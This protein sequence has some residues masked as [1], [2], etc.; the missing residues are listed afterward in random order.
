MSEP[1]TAVAG[2]APHSREG[3]GRAPQAETTVVSRRRRRWRAVALIGLTASAVI[4]VF[5]VIS[6]RYWV[7][8]TALDGSWRLKIATGYIQVSTL[9]EGEL[10]GRFDLAENQRLMATE[11]PMWYAMWW[12]PARIRIVPGLMGGRSTDT[13]IMLWVPLSAAIGVTGL[14]M[15]GGRRARPGCCEQCGYDLR[16]NVSNRCPECG[17]EF[18][19][20]GTALP[21]RVPQPRS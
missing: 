21:P 7:V 2:L 4:G 6:T 15:Y 20:A 9:G 14:A 3:F 12:P 13:R 18:H 5:Y 11:M 19:L 17:E 1:A 10:F 8:W 16:G